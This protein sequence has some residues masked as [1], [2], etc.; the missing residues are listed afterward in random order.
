MR[1][2]R[3]VLLGLLALGCADCSHAS[4]GD[5]HETTASPSIYPLEVSLTDEHARPV[6]LDVDRGHLTIVS[7]FYGSCPVACPLIVSH[8]KEIE[9]R[10]SPDAKKDLRVLLVSFDPAHD[11]PVALTALAQERE[12]D[13]D[14]WTLAT[15]PDDDVRQ[16]A[17][18]L[19][20]SYRPLAGGGFA[21]DAIL[22]VLDREG[23]PIARTDDANVDALVAAIDSHARP[24]S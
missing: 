17:A 13:L 10:V 15:G 6:G 18:V 7:M 19:G 22:T 8:V 2:V 12:L 24:G 21:H 1:F 3:L 5:T 16:I 14:R 9:S 11:T 4:A 20:I 23:R